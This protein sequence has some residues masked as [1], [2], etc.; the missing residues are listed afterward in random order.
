MSTTRNA[1]F[2]LIAVGLVILLLEVVL[3][4]WA[5]SGHFT[6]T[7]DDP[8]IHLALAENLARFGHYG[9]NMNEY[10]SPSSSIIWPL[11]L[12]PFFPLGLGA[13]GPLILNIVF[14]LATLPL[15]HR[16]VVGA[17]Q[18]HERPA[19]SVSW[20]WAFFIFFAVGGFG[21]V[22]TG[23]E[24]SL[25]VLLTVA[26]MDL[27][28]RMRLTAGEGHG[29]RSFYDDRLLILCIVLSPLVRFEGLAISAFAILMLIALGKLRVAIFSAVLIGLSL[30]LYAYAM[31][32]LGLPWLPSS[33]LMKSGAAADIASTATIVE[34][35]AG[36]ASHVADNVML[37]LEYA[38]ARL[39]LLIAVL[40]TAYAV[41]AWFKA[42]SA[43]V[44]AGSAQE[45]AANQESRARIRFDRIGSRSGERVTLIYVAG[46]ITVI[47]LHLAFG[48]FG[49]MGRYQ[50]YLSAFTLCAAIQVFS[51][52]L[53]KQH[54]DAGR[55]WLVRIGAAALTVVILGFQQN[56]MPIVETPF[57]ARNIYEQQFHMHEFVT[58]HWKAPIA[59]NDIGQVSFQNDLYVLDLYGLASEEARELG[60]ARDPDLLPKLTGKRDIHLAIIYE[61]WFPGY[62]PADWHKIGEMRLV[63]PRIITPYDSVSFFVFGLDQ[64]GCLRAATQLAEFK[65][66]LA[67]PETLTVDG[68]ACSRVN[69]S[70][71][72][73]VSA[74]D[75]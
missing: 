33:V 69:I 61:D 62:I 51:G 41:R 18:S 32:A 67:Q 26:I 1:S 58:R 73:A 24:H 71:L 36:A 59:V 75:P 72:R 35:V 13:Y 7:L 6:Y 53:L 16:L 68:D 44:G 9:I 14:A 17:A 47:G 4:M 45:N 64:A 48:R 21:I 60:R 11:L 49:W 31:S 28:N 54:A 46:V 66:T 55:A 2:P 27:V 19:S 38:E 23:M 37:N 65:R 57:A 8:Y 50:A 20:M 43:E 10:S 29:P 39:I 34:K 25:H 74:T 3:V 5:S 70:K 22:F 63:S 56:V 12:I 42:F 52:P 15:L 30:G 40:L